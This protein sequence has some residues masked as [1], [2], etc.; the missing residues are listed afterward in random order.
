MATPGV[1]VD[2]RAV[3]AKPEQERRH[4]ADAR[5]IDGD[6]RVRGGAVAGKQPWVKAAERAE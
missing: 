2:L 4:V 6:A 5:R 1:G 3:G